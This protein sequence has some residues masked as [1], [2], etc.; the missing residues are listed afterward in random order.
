MA[1]ERA[2]VADALRERDAAIAAS[3]QALVGRTIDADEHPRRIGEARA[4][5]DAALRQDLGHA[6]R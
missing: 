4:K 6:P 5:F 3:A 2:S 1:D